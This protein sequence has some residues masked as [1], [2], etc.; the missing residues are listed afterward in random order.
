MRMSWNPTAAGRGC[1]RAAA[2]VV[3][4]AATLFGA[5]TAPRAEPGFPNR[6]IRILVPYGAG[7]VGDLTMRILAQKMTERMGRQVITENRPGAGGLLAAKAALD[8][9]ADGYTLLEAGNGAAIGMSLFRTRPYNMLKDFTFISITA[10]FEILIATSAKSK[11]ETLGDI[12]DAARKNPGKLN[13]GAINP[14][15]TQ[16]LSAHLLKQTAGIDVTVV[17]Y[18]TTPE[19]IT[20]LLRNDIDVGF[21]YYAGFQPAIVDNKI[22]VVAV[23]G[24][25]RNPLLPNVPTAAERAL[26][27]FVVVGWNAITAPGQLAPDVL[28]VL[29]RE[30]N[31]ALADPEVQA[32]TE[33]MGI[34]SAGSTP[35]AMRERMAQEVKR[36]AEVIEKAGIERQ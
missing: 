19:L 1:A 33:R 9:P 27:G 25:K 14:G 29:N 5:M 17:T 13:F 22:R 35:D 32:K 26:P 21:D 23:S 12:I 20:A 8:F 3:A 16:N 6:P 18:R 31:A 24:E 7:G 4:V 10:S 28:A 11:Y 34:T 30:V 2:I 36:W 15:S